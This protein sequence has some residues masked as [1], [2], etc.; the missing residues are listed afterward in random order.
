MTI[1]FSSCFFLG[2][3]SYLTQATEIDMTEA[4]VRTTD[5]DEQ[6]RELCDNFCTGNERK[7]WLDKVIVRWDDPPNPDGS[8]V[9]EVNVRMRNRHAYRVCPLGRCRRIT[10]YSDTSTVKFTGFFSNQNCSTQGFTVTS[11]NEIYKVLGGFATLLA[12]SG[13][14]AIAIKDKV[15]SCG[16]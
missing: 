16:L 2:T 10:A 7:S 9:V 13:P 11:A 14:L 8:T 12:N 1:A 6:A 3:F 4:V 15:P 5:I